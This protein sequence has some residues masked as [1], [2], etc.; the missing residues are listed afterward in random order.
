[1]NEI[2]S[3]CITMQKEIEELE[4]E[5]AELKS[6]KEACDIIHFNAK[7]SL[8]FQLKD[9]KK[10]KSDLAQA[11][12]CLGKENGEL[13]YENKKLKEG[14]ELRI[15]ESEDLEAKLAEKETELVGLKNGSTKLKIVGL[16]LQ[17]KDLEAKLD[18]CMK[19]YAVCFTKLEG[20]REFVKKVEWIGQCACYE[21]YFCPE[22]LATKNEGHK[23]DCKLFK[24][25]SANGD[26]SEQG[27][28]K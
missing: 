26:L 28:G 7:K 3:D 16:E 2:R 14:Y 27:Q 17:V 1:M 8:E 13:Q 20:L 15:A 12:E 23:S 9:L 6:E 21:D 4:K 22:C 25:L 10:E 18:D 5:N 11:V 19:N 24:I